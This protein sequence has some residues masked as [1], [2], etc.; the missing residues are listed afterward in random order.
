MEKIMV[1]LNQQQKLNRGMMKL[2]DV[3][4]A[5]KNTITWKHDATLPYEDEQD[6]M[7]Q[8]E[9]YKEAMVFNHI[10]LGIQP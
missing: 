1:Y 8:H 9:K 7:Q 5:S 3:I 4:S 10:R 2:M 6:F